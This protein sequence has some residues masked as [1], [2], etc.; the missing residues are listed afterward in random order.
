MNTSQGLAVNEDLGAGPLAAFARDTPSISASQAAALQPAHTRQPAAQENA[1]RTVVP[2]FMTE[3]VVSSD[4][5]TANGTEYVCH[6]LART[7]WAWVRMK[8]RSS[9]YNCSQPTDPA[10]LCDQ[11]HGHVSSPPSCSPPRSS[12]STHTL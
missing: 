11:G 8:T 3:G 10:T 5:A 4:E 2:S 9:I 12:T 7:A 1:E 6:V